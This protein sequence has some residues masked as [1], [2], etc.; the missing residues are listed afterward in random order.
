MPHARRLSR[1]L[2]PQTSRTTGLPSVTDYAPRFPGKRNPLQT[3]FF[4][5]IAKWSVKEDEKLMSKVAKGKE[6][7]ATK[8]KKLQNVLRSKTKNRHTAFKIEI[9]GKCFYTNVFA[10]RMVL[11]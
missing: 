3:R 8:M 10:S 5:S 11:A 1:P 2:E 4:I 7:T 9:R 6:K